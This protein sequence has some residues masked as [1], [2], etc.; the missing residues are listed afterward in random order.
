VAADSFGINDLSKGQL[1]VMRGFY[2]RF[3]NLATQALI[4]SLYTFAASSAAGMLLLLM[5]L[6]AR[7]LPRGVQG[8]FDEIAFTML[9][10]LGWVLIV[11]LGF[12]LLLTVVCQRIMP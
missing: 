4:L 10:P 3:E 11:S 12:L 5:V 7:W 1:N 8:L 6:I 9:T 2:G